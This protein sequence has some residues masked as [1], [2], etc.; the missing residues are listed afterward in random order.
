M[1]EIAANLN[2][3]GRKFLAIYFSFLSEYV[4][5]QNPILLLCFYYLIHFIMGVISVATI[6]VTLIPKPT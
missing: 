5:I 1:D 4:F 2:A 3:Q 6:A